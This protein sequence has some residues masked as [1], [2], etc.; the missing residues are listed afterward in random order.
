[1]NVD[2][3]WKFDVLDFLEFGSSTA[4]SDHFGF[5][6]MTKTGQKIAGRAACDAVWSP[7]PCREQHYHSVLK[8]LMEIQQLEFTARSSHP[9]SPI[10]ADDHVVQ[11]VVVTITC[12]SELQIQTLLL[13]TYNALHQI[14]IGPIF[15]P[16]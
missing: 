14:F 8:V 15:I 16:G 2:I 12:T 3:L 6:F 10:I 9:H 7:V 13:F 5:I 1:M 4:A 11:T